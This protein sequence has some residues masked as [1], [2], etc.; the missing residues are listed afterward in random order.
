MRAIVK[1]PGR[2]PTVRNVSNDLRALQDIVG[3][4]IETV[5]F[6]DDC[7]AICNEEGRLRG[8]APNI[9]FCG[10]DFV[11]PVIFVGA[12]GEEFTDLTQEQAAFLI[13]ELTKEEERA[14]REWN[15]EN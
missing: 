11:G 1:E 10:V 2:M 12:D 15:Y 14:R 9:C 13:R 3:G 7:C 8:M 6:T 4:Y 5:T